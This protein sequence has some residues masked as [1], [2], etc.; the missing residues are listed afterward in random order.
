[1]WGHGT[2]HPAARR[3]SHTTTPTKGTREVR[4]RRLRMWHGWLSD[5]AV[6]ADSLACRA[7][8]L[9]LPLLPSLPQ[10]QPARGVVL[11]ARVHAAR[12]RLEERMQARRRPLR[13]VLRA[14]LPLLLRLLLLLAVVVLLGCKGGGLLGL[15]FGG[16][17]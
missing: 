10:L 2:A 11:L 13:A 6:A 1:M 4:H 14:S 17:A 9:A 15:S 7:V 8:V 5:S 16:L 3:S 12:A